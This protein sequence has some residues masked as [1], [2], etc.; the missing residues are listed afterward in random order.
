MTQHY[1]IFYFSHFAQLHLTRAHM[2]D[3]L[4][5]HTTFDEN[6]QNNY[7]SVTFLSQTQLLYTDTNVN[8]L[9]KSKLERE[10]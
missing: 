10:L 7:N 8:C 2:K 6:S 5:T 3:E 4:Y 1:I 9:I